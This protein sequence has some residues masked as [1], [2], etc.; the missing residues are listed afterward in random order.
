MTTAA[1]V[2]TRRRPL[3]K[4]SRQAWLTLHFI[5]MGWYLSGLIGTVALLLLGPAGGELRRRLWTHYLGGLFDYF[6]II[7]GTL[8]TLATGLWLSWRTKWGVTKHWWII[9]KLIANVGLMTF[10]A[11]VLRTYAHSYLVSAGTRAGSLDFL[12]TPAYASLRG[13][14]LWLS[15]GATLVVLVVVYVSVVKPWGKAPAWSAWLVAGTLGYTLGVLISFVLFRGPA[16]PAMLPLGGGGILAGL[17]VRWWRR[18][19]GA[20]AG[21]RKP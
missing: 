21:F 14:Y 12:E 15:I 16:G 9:V 4:Q 2:T 1:P 8:G 17:A 3:G 18:P 5:C 19:R 6:L 10:G 11:L 20:S 13:G 7:P